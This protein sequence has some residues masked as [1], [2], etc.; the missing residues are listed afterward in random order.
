MKV[1]IYTT[2]LGNVNKL[3]DP[4]F[5]QRYPLYCFTDGKLTYSKDWNIINVNDINIP[6]EVPGDRISLTRY[7]KLLPHIHFPDYDYTIWVDAAHWM[8]G[9][10]SRY[11]PFEEDM[12]L[13]KHANTNCMYKELDD[14]IQAI[15]PK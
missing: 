11:I 4:K 7:F 10:L 6:L 5:S 8:I 1:A 9:D 2:I 14:V 13:F 3:I 12:L 15:K